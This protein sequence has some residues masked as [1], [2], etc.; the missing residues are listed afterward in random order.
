MGTPTSF[1]KGWAPQPVYS[2]TEEW[3][4]QPD[5]FKG[6][7][8]NQCVRIASS[9]APQPAY[10]VMVKLGTPT[11]THLLKSWAPEPVGKIWKM[12]R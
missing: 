8:P 12:N 10:S 1:L 6:W 2:I 4:P 9:C 7:A 11:S 5:F 3:A